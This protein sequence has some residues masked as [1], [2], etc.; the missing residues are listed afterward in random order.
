MQSYVCMADFAYMQDKYDRPYD[1]VLRSMRRWYH[2]FWY[3]FVM[4]TVS[5][6]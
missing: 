5:E 6:A 3:D 2:S 4:F 1:L